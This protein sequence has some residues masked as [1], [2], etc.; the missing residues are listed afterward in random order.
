MIADSARMGGFHQ[1]RSEIGADPAGQLS[2]TPSK[3][4]ARSGGAQAK[5]PGS[6]RS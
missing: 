6:V 5:T 1:A 4:E 3:E 2:V